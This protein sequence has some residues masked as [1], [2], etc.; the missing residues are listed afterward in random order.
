M[1]LVNEHEIYRTAKEC[2]EDMAVYGHPN[3]EAYPPWLPDSSMSSSN[4]NP[5][6]YFPDLHGNNNCIFRND[7][8]KWMM[9]DGFRDYYLFDNGSD[10]CKMWFPAHSNCPDMNAYLEK[11]VE[12]LNPFENYYFPDFD[13]QSCG[14]GK[15]YP[16]RMVQEGFEKWYLFIDAS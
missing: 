11:P 12:E 14:H 3:N 13:E 8:D 10:C 9:E 4:T 6:K 16:A 5:Q 1:G 15:D 2:C 7:Y